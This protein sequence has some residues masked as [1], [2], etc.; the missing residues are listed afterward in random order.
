MSENPSDEIVRLA[1]APNPPVAN[2]WAQALKEEGIRCKIV[3]DYLETGLG[4]I[5]GMRAEIWVHK[6]DAERA[7][8]IISDLE[9]ENA[10]ESTDIDDE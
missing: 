8:A 4:N 10:A 6:E 5:P 1:T 3:G 7:Q 9:K 2:I